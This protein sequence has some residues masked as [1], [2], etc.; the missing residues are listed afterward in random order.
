MFIIN[1]FKNLFKFIFYIIKNLLWLVFGGII[2][3]ILWMLLGVIF[4]A[5]I[6]IPLG[7]VICEITPLGETV[8]PFINSLGIN[9]ESL[10]EIATP[11]LLFVSI[12]SSVILIPFG[13]A[14]FKIAFYAFAGTDKEVYV[15]FASGALD[16]V[17]N[18]FWLPIIGFPVFL[19][20]TFI[21]V[22]LY[23][24]IIGIPL[25]KRYLNMALLT[26]LPFGAT[27]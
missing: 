17:W 3:W 14:C 27:L 20:Y 7:L 4:Y 1:L 24:T 12:V 21:G 8:I 13:N 25:G 15:N 9:Y 16:C 26:L 19:V 5:L 2:H 6:I 18:I 23:M 11:V 22:F 10:G